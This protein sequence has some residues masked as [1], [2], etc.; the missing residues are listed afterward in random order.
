MDGDVQQHY[1]AAEQ[2]YGDGHFAEAQSIAST[3]LA[4]LNTASNSAEEEEAR[5]A[6]RA[7]VTLLLGHIHFHGL[8]QPEQ[9]LTHYQLAL[10]NQPPDTLREL[11]EQGIERSQA[12]IAAAPLDDTHQPAIEGNDNGTS[13]VAQ[14]TQV[15]P[16]ELDDIGI[17]LIRDPFLSSTQARTFI[18]DGPDSNV[19]N[20][21]PQSQATASAAPWMGE[22]A[23]L[24]AHR[25]P[26]E[27]GRPANSEADFS[28][29]T[30]SPIAGATAMTASSESTSPIAP[31]INS[32][33]D[34]KAEPEDANVSEKTTPEL[35]KAEVS[36]TSS[37]EAHED[38]SDPFPD[39]AIDSQPEL[40]LSPWLLRRTLSLTK[41]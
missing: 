28:E 29:E 23:T 13:L 2:A 4:Q 36:S 21:S 39:S 37:T 17:A 41:D 26:A 3:L 18:G 12:E 20:S 30:Q 14:A 24:M 7:F 34:W 22:G 9:A 19:S 35:G 10:E 27:H 1:L 15:D 16:P 6:W 25:R 5:L 32:T 31:E 11:A 38:G 8:N 40:D 33:E